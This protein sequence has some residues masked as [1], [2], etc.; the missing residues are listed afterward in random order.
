MIAESRAEEKEIMVKLVMNS[1]QCEKYCIYKRNDMKVR[2]FI[3]GGGE[4]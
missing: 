1:W 2:Q 3:A 4:R